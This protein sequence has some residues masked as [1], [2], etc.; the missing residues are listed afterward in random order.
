MPDENRELFLGE[1]TKSLQEGSFVKLTLGKYR[2]DEPDLKNLF[3]RQ[4]HIKRTDQLSFLYRFRTKDVVKN[5]PV[6]TGLDVVRDVLRVG[7]QSGHLFTLKQD[8]QIEF[9]KKG[10]SK[11][12]SSKPTFT[13]KPK[14]SHDS[15]KHR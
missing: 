4:V 10:K 3:I 7:F 13:V 12:A 9:S 5:F 6:N 1:L 14:K 11:L 2:G 8:M 15:K